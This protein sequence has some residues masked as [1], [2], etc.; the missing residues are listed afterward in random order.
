MM[1]RDFFEVL[2]TRGMVRRFKDE[3]IPFDLLTEILFSASRAP[4]TG[5]QQLMKFVCERDHHDVKKLYAACFEQ[6]AVL[7][8]HASVVVVAETDLAERHFGL[9]GK[10]LYVVQDCAAAIQNML[11]TAHALGLG[12]LWIHAF[13]EV[14]ISDLY[15]IPP[16]ARPQ[17]VLLFGYPD[18]EPDTRPL[19][20]FRY[21][22][23]W[24]QYG[25]K[26]KDPHLVVWHLSDQWE[27]W[28]RH[29]KEFVQRRANQ[30][31]SRVSEMREVEE[32]DGTEQA[33][34]RRPKE[35]VLAAQEHA[36]QATNEFLKSLKKPGR[37]TV[38]PKKA[39]KR[40]GARKSAVGK[41]VSNALKKRKR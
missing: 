5:D 15:S 37:G 16:Y 10:R 25:A 22:T 8:A 34:P 27:R 18:E 28:A 1:Q 32:S 6:D 21:L 38:S 4:T 11:L 7:T 3:P 33:E 12:A 2:F 14:A 13:D 41:R 35:Y 19:K 9:R 24:S 30:V 31:K 29:A 26:Y 40:S 20:D 23:N 17:A 39:A 36:R